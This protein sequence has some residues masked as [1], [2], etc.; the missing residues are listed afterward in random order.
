MIFVL[1]CINIYHFIR[2]FDQHSSPSKNKSF[3]INMI[4]ENIKH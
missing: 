1:F 2:P 4:N 3:K